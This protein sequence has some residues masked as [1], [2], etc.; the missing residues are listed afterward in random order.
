MQ[1]F[2]MQTHVKLTN[3]YPKY[4]KS[5]HVPLPLKKGQ[6]IESITLTK[7]QINNQINLKGKTFSHVYGKFDLHMMEKVVMDI[8]ETKKDSSVC[9]CRLQR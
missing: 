7:T 6:K 1:V 8:K 4:L 3:T 2:D 5:R 9:S